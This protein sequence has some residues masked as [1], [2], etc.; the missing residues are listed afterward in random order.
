ME[1]KQEK[2]KQYQKEYRE[3]N[4][5]KQKLYHQEY[6]KNNNQKL[7]AYRSEY[8]KTESGKKYQRIQT[9]KKRGIICED[10][11]IL[12]D[13]FINCNKCEKCDNDLVSGN[14]KYGRT[15]DHDHL[16]GNIR[17]ILCRSCNSGLPKQ[18]IILKLEC[19]N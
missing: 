12:Y 15:L 11:D 8:N 7:N 13:R 3:K 9:W 5:L 14:S 10:W 18:K 6:L 2:I 16:T 17:N 19:K 1:K 4:K